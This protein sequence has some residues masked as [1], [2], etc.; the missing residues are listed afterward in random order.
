MSTPPELAHLLPEAAVGAVT[1]VRPIVAGLSGAGVWAVTAGR[2]ELVLRVAAPDPAWDQQLR[3]LRRAADAGV[4]P[5]IVHVDQAARAVV[6]ERVAGVPLPA[7]LATAADRGAVI[8]GVVDQLRAVHALDPAGV[9]PRD[10]LAHARGLHAAQRA[11]PGFPAWAADLGPVFDAAQA[12]L[13]RDPRRAVCHND[14]NPGNVLW[15]GARAW[16][17]DWD[18][19]GLGH[20]LYDL[21]ALA[22]FLQLDDGVARGLLARHEGGVPD[23]VAVEVL[24]ALRRVAAL[25]TGLLFTSMVPDLAALPAA[26]PA[27]SSVYAGLR[28]GA[29]DLQQARGRAAFGLAL[30]GLGAPGRD[31][32]SAQ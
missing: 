11:R 13:D 14:L 1:A 15:D 16:L 12:A 22:M 4:A 18:V 28:T 32:H 2:G 19:A 8:V 6:S 25:L 5:A 7:A 23:A 3:V 20:P 27:L 17:V 10:A 29:L 26:V 9:E 24:G 31:R 30:L 21:A